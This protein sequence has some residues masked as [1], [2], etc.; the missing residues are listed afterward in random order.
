MTPSREIPSCAE[1]QEPKASDYV[2]SLALCSPARS[3]ESTRPARR[4]NDAEMRPVRTDHLDARAGRHVKAALR[5]DRGAVAAARPERHE[6]ALIGER[7]VALHV[8]RRER[9]AVG[10]IERLLIPAEN[11]AVGGEV[12]AVPRDRA[13]RVGV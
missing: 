1:F 2:T 9:R 13:L 7:S 4:W 3:S 6:L 12:L 5:V 8:E 10:H 11:H